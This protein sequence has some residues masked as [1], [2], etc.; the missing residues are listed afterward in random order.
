MVSKQDS[1]WP[2]KALFPADAQRLR[3]ACKEAEKAVTKLQAKRA[4]TTDVASK[5]N[6]LTPDAGLTLL[7]EYAH[8]LFFTISGGSQLSDEEAV[9]MTAALEYFMAEVLELSG[10]VTHSCSYSGGRIVPKHIVTAVSQDKEL[11]AMMQGVAIADRGNYE[12]TPRRVYFI[13]DSLEELP[14]RMGWTKIA[15]HLFTALKYEDW[16]LVVPMPARLPSFPA[17]TCTC[18]PGRRRP[19]G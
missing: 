13:A 18:R 7:V 17:P 2:A 6:T 16:C 10:R 9:A 11:R 15:E 12:E 4:E 3:H 5:V 1:L 14:G 8:L 19:P